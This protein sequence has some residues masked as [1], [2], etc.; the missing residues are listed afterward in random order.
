MPVNPYMNNV[1]G[2]NYS[3]YNNTAVPNFQINTPQ[4]SNDMIVIPVQNEEAVKNYPV[5]AGLSV[6]LMDYEH[7]KFW[8]KTTSANGLS[9]STEEYDFSPVEKEQ[10]TGNDEKYATQEDM[11][12]VMKSIDELRKMLDDLTK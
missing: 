4:Q 2:G 9:T 10:S 5:A 12:K 7:K 11:K 6:L 8:V 1:Y 3:P